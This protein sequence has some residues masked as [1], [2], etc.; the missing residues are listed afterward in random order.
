MSST[1]Q[2]DLELFIDANID[3]SEVIA[4]ELDD[5]YKNLNDI[6]VVEYLMTFYKKI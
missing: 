3:L 1:K 6:N 4:C 2:R 5:E